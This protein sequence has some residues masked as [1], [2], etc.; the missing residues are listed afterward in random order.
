MKFERKPI[1]LNPTCA[2][3]GLSIKDHTMA[4]IKICI[5]KR[6]SSTKPS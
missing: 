3:C 6:R 5:E 2:M 4:E 1:K